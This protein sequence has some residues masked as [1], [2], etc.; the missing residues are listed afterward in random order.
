M[1]MSKSTSIL[2]GL[3]DEEILDEFVKR[4]QCDG[5]ILIYLESNTEYGFAKWSNSNGRKWV[6]ELFTSAQNHNSIPNSIQSV[7]NYEEPLAAI[8]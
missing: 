1:S 6:N 2:T 3:T 8:L 5:A 7:L 4:F